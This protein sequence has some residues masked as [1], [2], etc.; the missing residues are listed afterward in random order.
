MINYGD[1][2]KTKG[3]VLKA[4]N[5]GIVTRNYI[6]EIGLF[7]VSLLNVSVAV[8]SPTFW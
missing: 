6:E 2:I 5:H 4:V 7:L 1:V 8:A 3:L